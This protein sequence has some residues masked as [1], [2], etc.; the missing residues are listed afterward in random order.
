MCGVAGIL[1]LRDSSIMNQDPILRMI[2]MI[3]H[4]G[5]DESGIYVDEKIALGSVRL[6]II[7]LAAGTQPIA[8]E[9]ESLWIV[10][11]GEIFNY[12]ELK[13]ELLEGGHKFRTDTDIEVIIH[14]Y[15]DM[16]PSCL[17]KLNGQFAVAIWDNI[18]KE[19]FLA[20]DR[21]G[22]RPLFYCKSS[23]KIIFA[24]EIKA[25]FVNEEVSREIN[26]NVLQ[27]VFCCWSPI[28]DE[29][30][31]KNVR[32]VPPGHFLIIRNGEVIDR[33]YWQIP[34]YEKDELVSVGFPE[35]CDQLHSLLLDAVKI[36]LHADVPVGAYLSGGLDS[37]IIA[38][39]IS[40]NFGNS[41]KTF[42]MTFEQPDYDESSYQRRMVS[43]LG[44][45]NHD[46]FIS[47]DQIAEHFPPVIWHCEGPLLRTAPVPLMLLSSLVRNDGFKV[48]LTGEGADEI[49]GGYNIYKEAK[50]RAFWSK[51]LKSRCRPLLLKELYPYV[52][53]DSRAKNYLQQYF[54]VS[55]AG[56]KNPFFTHE[57]RWRNSARNTAFFSEA[58]KSAVISHSEEAFLELIPQNFLKRDILSR[59]QFLEMKGFLSNYL[60][61]SQGDRVAMANSVETRMPF[62]DYRVIDFAAKI[63][64]HWKINGLNEKYILKKAFQSFLPPEIVQRRKHPFRAPIHEAFFSAK[65]EHRYL[66]DMLS[67]SYL[68]KS[69]YFDANKVQRL[70]R[71]F[72]SGQVRSAAEFSNMALLGI[73]S[74]Q[75][76]YH[77]YI[78]DWRPPSRPAIQPLKIATNRKVLTTV[79]F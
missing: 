79:S 73:L 36:R 7:D 74:T 15:E 59:A 41:L 25:I 12:L 17:D 66:E 68:R 37:S 51:D 5:P 11:N 4:R 55:E 52:M 19:L 24:S 35:A 6:S 40:D 50:I 69:G 57:I 72:D 65:K 77:Q 39:L 29:T 43:H 31:F 71:L 76:V 75:L 26:L 2:S 3:Q 58:A 46:I 70:V 22:I 60:L 38:S 9:D 21:V 49:F 44:T 34:Y 30:I 42:S 47:N 28:S 16:G 13:D 32:Q 64:P 78:D 67:Q 53:K 33:L 63:P 8:N 1:L 10:C 54:S 23:Q 20:R 56:F 27:H 61:S 48:V 14:L 18:K 45:D 62:L